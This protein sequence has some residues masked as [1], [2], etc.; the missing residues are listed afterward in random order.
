MTLIPASYAFGMVLLTSSLAAF[1]AYHLGRIVHEY[2]YQ[3]DVAKRR[4]WLTAGKHLAPEK[5]KEELHLD[6]ELSL[7][8]RVRSYRLPKRDR[9][10]V[11]LT[12]RAKE[13][14]QFI[15]EAIKG[16]TDVQWLMKMNGKA[17]D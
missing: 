15:D 13:R 5:P 7:A 6:Q 16:N 11:Y 10:I 4:V 1:F 12:E 14:R 9:K 2:R 8:E 17:H 3:K